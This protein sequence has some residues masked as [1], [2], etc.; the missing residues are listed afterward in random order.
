MI[1]SATQYGRD[2]Y[3]RITAMFRDEGF[4]VNY[5]RVERLWRR[6][7]L[8]VPQKHPER[9]QLWLNDGSCVRLRPAYRDHVWSCD[10]VQDRPHEGRAFRLLTLIDA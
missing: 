8:K 6:E 7:G 5:K 9:R 10:F 2:G 3:R 4:K 1:G